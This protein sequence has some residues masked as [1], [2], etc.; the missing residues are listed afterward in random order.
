[1]IRHIRKAGSVRTHKT[2]VNEDRNIE[3]IIFGKSIS[4]STADSIV[5]TTPYKTL[6]LIVTERL[7]FAGTLSIIQ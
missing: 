5:D 3:F 1:M 2:P 4:S 7:E 6:T